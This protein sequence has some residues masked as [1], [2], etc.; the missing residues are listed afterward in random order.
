MLGQPGSY[1]LGRFC[2]SIVELIAMIAIGYGVLAVVMGLT[3]GQEFGPVPMGYGPGAMSALPGLVLALVGFFI[4]AWTQ[5]ARARFDTAEMTKELLTSL[6]K[7]D[8]EG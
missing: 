2:L 5:V 8:L 3:T 4:M 6:T 1:K 7:K